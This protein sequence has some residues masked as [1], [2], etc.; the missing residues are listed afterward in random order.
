MTG[1]SSGAFRDSRG[2]R[3]PRSMTDRAELLIAGSRVAPRAACI[4]T[5][6]PP[7]LVGRPCV[8]R[9]AVVLACCRSCGSWSSTA[10]LQHQPASSRATATTDTVGRLR[11]CSRRH[12]RWCRRRLPASARARTAAGWPSARRARSRLGRSGRRWCQAA[13]TSSRRAWPLPVLVIPPWTRR[14]PGGELRGHQPEVGADRGAG[15]PVPVGDLDAEPDR[16]QRGDPAQAAQPSHRPGQRLGLG[17]LFDR[18]VEPVAAGVHREHRVEG[19]V[20]GQLH[21][22]PIEVLAAQPVGVRA[23][24]R[25]AVP[26]Q[27]LAQQQLGEPV[28]RPHQ[29]S[30]G[31]FAGSHQ[32]PGGFLGLGGDPHRRQ[33]PDAQQPRQPLGVAAVGLD[34]VPGR[35]LQLRGRHHLAAHPGRGQ[36]PGQP[37]PGRAG[38]IGHRHRPRQRDDPVHDRLGLRCH[39]LGADLARLVVDRAPHDR[40]SMNVQTDPR[41]LC[42]HRRLP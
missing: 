6:R 33:L 41:T 17:H 11:R 4:R 40:T 8:R 2:E 34:L 25:A 14:A 12:Q 37:E 18:G 1:C 35:A 19:L 32:V 28:P 5:R 31:V 15:E 10:R 29:I 27:A 36:R 42:Q 16:G 20:E 26:D 23:G 24:P 9:R 22:A 30:A 21:P 13:S 39:P 38:L 3:R 7:G